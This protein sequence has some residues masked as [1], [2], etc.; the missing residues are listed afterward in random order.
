MD[1]SRPERKRQLHRKR[2]TRFFVGLAISLTVITIMLRFSGGPIRVSMDEIWTGEVQQGDM[3]LEVRGAGTLIPRDTWWMTATTSGKVEKIHLR[4]GCFVKANELLVELSNPELVRKMETSKSQME[5]DDAAIRSFEA[6]Q[7]IAIHKI[8]SELEQLEIELE[9]ADIEKGAIFTLY[10]EGLES[11]FSK[12][13]VEANVKKIR[14]RIKYATIEA[15]FQKQIMIAKLDEKRVLMN[16]NHATYDFLK[17]KCDA[18]Q[19][20]TRNPGLLDKLNLELGQQVN[21]GEVLAQI[22]NNKDL[23]ARI[24][25]PENKLRFLS[26]G[27]K[28]TVYVNNSEYTAEITDLNPSV[29]QGMVSMDLD[30]QSIHPGRLHVGS[31]VEATIHVMEIEDTLF[32]DRPVNINANSKATI[33]CLDA[34]QNLAHQNTVK[35]GEASY[36]KVQV[37]HGLMAG[38][39]IILSDTSQWSESQTIQLK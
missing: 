9:Q 26:T 2:M 16:Q 30:I 24:R 14:N 1:C 7:Q 39:R 8:K 6:E 35:F 31:A 22:V 17:Q 21:K 28:A 37:L 3:L 10:E 13:R 34:K 18:L 4:A 32:V 5:L 19:V 20:K 33:F 23:K 36:N 29:N 38:D 15:T 12:R 27:M 11:D 25:V